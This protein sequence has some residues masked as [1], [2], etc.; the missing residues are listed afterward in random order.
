MRVDVRAGGALVS[1]LVSV[2]GLLEQQR[3]TGAPLDAILNRHARANK[4]AQL[5]VCPGHSDLV[6]F[7]R[8]SG[9]I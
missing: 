1:V 9:G 8:A 5:C 6:R 3:D 2:L 7:L 4:I